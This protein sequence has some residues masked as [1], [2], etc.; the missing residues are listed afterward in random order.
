[1]GILEVHTWNSRFSHLEQPDRI[2]IDLDPGDEVGWVEVIDAARVVRQL[3]GALNLEC[4]VKTT[5]GRGLHI[6]IPLMARA[7]WSDCLAFAR[8]FAETL[9]RKDP[10]RFTSKFAKAGREEKVLVDYLRN[11]RTNTSVAA[12]STRARPNAP[13]S[14]P[15][16]W[17][18][19][20][21]SRLPDRFT[22][23]TV[24]LRLTRLRADPWRG[25]W[26]SRQV[27]P[28][29]AVAALNQL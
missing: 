2:V 6:V 7:D 20:S 25:Y 19:L 13:V 1:M 4:F 23:Q 3:L 10:E 29:G 11:N 26:N 14:T 5:G 27:V 15:I 9:V 22:M 24:P 18:E 8:A 28:A 17:S 21:A 12:F 16:A